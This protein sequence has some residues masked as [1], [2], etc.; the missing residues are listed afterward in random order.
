M[1]F[2]TEQRE[3]GTEFISAFAQKAWDSK[4]FKEQ[5]IK[6]PVTTIEKVTGKDLTNLNKKIIV[7]DQT[8]ESIIYL[9][10]PAKVNLDELELTEEQLEQVAGGATIVLAYVAGTAIGIGVTWLVDEYIAN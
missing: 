5:L 6:D 7:E 1:N 10:L 9:N 4:S 2:T 3:K 8:D